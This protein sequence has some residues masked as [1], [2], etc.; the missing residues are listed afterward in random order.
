MSAVLEADRLGKRYRESALFGGVA[1]LLI[2]F[3]AV[4]LKRRAA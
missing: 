1:L 3:A 4:V 2:A